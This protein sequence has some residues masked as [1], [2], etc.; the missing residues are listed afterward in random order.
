MRAPMRATISAVLAA[1]VLCG[2]VQADE[3]SALKEIEKFRCLIKRDDKLP[4]NPVVEV[5]FLLAPA[6]DETLKEIQELKQLRVLSLDG[7]K[8]T[9]AGLKHLK[10]LKQLQ[11]LYL[12]R[13]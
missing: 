2:V 6:T 12:F 3:A 10:E 5:A 9:D 11:Q 13:T 1:A 8:V 4:G 7:T